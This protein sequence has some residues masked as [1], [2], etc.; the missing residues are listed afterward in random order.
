MCTVNGETELHLLLGGVD[1]AI[2]IQSDHAE[3]H[4]SST[5]LDDVAGF[6]DVFPA[7]CHRL[8][9]GEQDDPCLGIGGLQQFAAVA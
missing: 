1:A 2:L 7:C 3:S 4:P 9:W 6:G 5:V 8:Q